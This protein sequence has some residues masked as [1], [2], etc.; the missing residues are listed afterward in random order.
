MSS[1]ATTRGQ[2]ARPAIGVG[3]A[4]GPY[5]GW[6]ALLPLLLY[7]LPF[8]LLR[9]PS[10]EAWGGGS[11]GPILDYGFQTSGQNADIVIFGDSSALYGID[12][13]QMS[14]ELGI[15]VINLPNTL[16]SLNVTADLSLR[17][18]LQ[19]NRPPRLVIF[20]TAPYNL[21]Y[22]DKKDLSHAF[23]GEEMLLRHGSWTQIAAFGREHPAELL[24]APF[25]FYESNPKPAII[26]ALEHEHRS[27][28]IAARRGH[29]DANGEPLSASCKLTPSLAKPVPMT[30][31]ESLLQTYQTDK[32]ATMAYVAPIPLCS[33]ES[34]LLQRS[35]SEIG[36]HPPVVLAPRLF[37]RDQYFV[38]MMPPGVPIATELLVQSIHSD[39]KG[40]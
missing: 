9:L 40:F 29:S 33:N 16:G 12:P 7:L 17:R 37:R 20:Y 30:S 23:E 22:L 4:F 11:V 36:A 34:D 39:A 25:R 35:Y 19:T 5:L 18:Y 32:T 38:H 24:L 1:T 27:A 26:A 21:D 2:Q 8:F 3:N 6:L 13:L 14:S 31:V 28:G 15:K 10:F